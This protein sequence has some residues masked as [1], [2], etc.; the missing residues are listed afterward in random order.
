MTLLKCKNM[1]GVAH[2]EACRM[3]DSAGNHL[4]FAAVA[5]VDDASSVDDT[6]F[7]GR[8]PQ[9]KIW[10]NAWAETGSCVSFNKQATLAKKKGESKEGACIRKQRVKQ[11][12]VMSE[13]C[14]R[15]ARRRLREADS[16]LP[17]DG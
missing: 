7:K 13:V 6:S 17:F 12:R 11:L 4:S 15:K 9:P 3:L 2:R 14:K 1:E 16:V 8:V 10:R 5:K